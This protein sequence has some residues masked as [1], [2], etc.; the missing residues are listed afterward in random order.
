MKERLIDQG[1]HT[2][3]D[4]ES[5]NTFHVV[6]DFGAGGLQIECYSSNIY[7]SSIFTQRYLFYC[8]SF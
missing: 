8:L 4:V 5:H 3:N 2:N 1:F 6:G 7:L